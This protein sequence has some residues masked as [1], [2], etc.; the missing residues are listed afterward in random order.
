MGF[1]HYLK[2]F[3]RWWNP[4]RETP[5]PRP[6][7]PRLEALEDRHLP[8][9]LNLLTGQLLI[10]HAAAGSLD[11]WRVTVRQEPGSLLG[12]ITVSETRYEGVPRETLFWRGT[13]ES[14]FLRLLVTSVTIRLGDGNDSATLEN[15]SSFLP[16]TIDGGWGT[17][18]LQ[19]ERA[20]N[21][22]NITDNNAGTVGTAQFASV[23]ALRGLGSSSNRFVFSDGKRV[24]GAVFGSSGSADTVDYSAWNS[25][26]RLRQGTG[27]TGVETVLG[28]RSAG[29]TL[30]GNGTWN[31]T[32]TNAGTLNGTTFSSFENL[33]GGSE[34]NQ[35][36]FSDGKGLTGSIHGGS[37]SLTTADYSAY[38]HSVVVN[39]QAFWATGAPGGI[40]GVAHIIGGSS[41]D[42]LIAGS[43]WYITDSN[44]GRVGGIS[45]SSFE[46]LVGSADDNRFVFSDGKGVT[47]FLQGMSGRDTLDYGAYTTPVTVQLFNFIA[48]GAAGGA[49][50]FRSAFGG[51]AGDTLLGN[52]L[53]NV[54][55]GGAGNDVLDGRGGRDLLIGGVGADQLQGGTGDDI[56]ISGT[57]THDGWSVVLND[58]LARWS[59]TD[60]SYEQRITNLR[61]SG[62]CLDSTTVQQDTDVDTLTG[63]AGRDWF[64]AVSGLFGTRPGMPPPPP[65][66][67]LAD[68]VWMIL[69]LVLEEQLN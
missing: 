64:W 66:D 43:T 16:V 3:R 19:V 40:S 8:A 27:F 11:H 65:R 47:G 31:I 51:S 68:R 28:G 21:T 53:D 23:E 39:R 22:W 24:A 63:D 6:T 45:F 50:G 15:L 60:L 44:A 41:G 57:T 33:E 18:E 62:W 2:G 48:T 32:G 4:A 34:V 69:G 56:L 10:D 52:D 29:D 26:V 30:V 46:S 12:Q 54:L 67:T 37:N 14:Q 42:L 58:L 20:A 35:F 25:P 55:V 13:T 9:S 49:F 7:S 5:W 38:T 17:D 59:R 36:V 61:T 1:R